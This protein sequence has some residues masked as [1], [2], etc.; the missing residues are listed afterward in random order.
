MKKITPIKKL[1]QNYLKDKNIIDKII[2]EIDPRKNDQIIEIGPGS[3][4]LTE[5]LAE[6]NRNLTLVEIDRRVKEELK[7]RFTDANFIEGDFLKINLESI[8]ERD[9]IVKV[10]GNIPYNITSPILFKLI[11]FRENINESVLVV[12]DEVAKRISAPYRTKDYGILSVIMTYFADVKYCFRISPNVFHPKPKVHSA[13]IHVYFGNNR[14]K[15]IDE[16]LFIKIVKA[17]F[18]H[19]RKTLKNS[20]SNSIFENY[21][22]SGINLDFSKRAEELKVS[23]FVYLTKMLQS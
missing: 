18:G 3:G 11:E 14:A 22:F 7:S 2:L 4:S 15:E 19:R 12:Q 21:D 17:S 9:R 16:E 10:V 1:G 5:G 6:K 8:L 23:D 13:L 20:L